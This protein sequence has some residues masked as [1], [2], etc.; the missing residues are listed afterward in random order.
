MTCHF[1]EKWMPEPNSGCWLWLGAV[2]KKG[3]GI[4]GRRGLAHRAAWAAH[5]GRAPGGACVLHRCDTPPCVNP[6]HL[7]LGTQADNVAD[8]IAKRRD[9]KASGDDHPRRLRPHLWP[10]G[11]DHWTKSRPGAV[12]GEANGRARLTAVDVE[13]ARELHRS[14]VAFRALAR[15]FGVD[16][17]TITQAVKGE[18]W[19]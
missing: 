5:H 14:G 12:A 1:D 8:M 3:Y 15:I 17:R 19:T 2:N 10:S 16:R 18:T 13:R 9:R 7:F 4:D 11:D 6:E